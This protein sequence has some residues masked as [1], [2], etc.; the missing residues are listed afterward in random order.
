MSSLT[1]AEMYN[2]SKEITAPI[3]RAEADKSAGTIGIS[4][5]FYHISQRQVL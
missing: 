3:F 1:L 5:D 4:A 2:I